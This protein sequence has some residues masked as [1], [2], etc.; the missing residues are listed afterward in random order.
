MKDNKQALAIAY[1]VK[2]K[3]QHKAMGGMVKEDN[4]MELPVHSHEHF[5]SAEDGLE[6]PFHS[7]DMSD[8]DELAEHDMEVHSSMDNTMGNSD[9][10]SAQS[11]VK[12]IIDRLRKK[13]MGR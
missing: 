5:L 4:D 1:A 8:S 11:S 6:T 3:A 2:K 10:D 12:A 7:E 13:H 9:H